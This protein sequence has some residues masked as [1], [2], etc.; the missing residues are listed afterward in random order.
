MSERYPLVELL[1]SL[2]DQLREAQRQAAEDGKDDMLKLKDC[3]IELALTWEKSGEGGIKFWVVELGAGAS[4]SST[5]TITINMEP[6]GP[7]MILGLTE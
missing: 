3:S 7:G 5:Q 2:G 6:V 4:R 1:T